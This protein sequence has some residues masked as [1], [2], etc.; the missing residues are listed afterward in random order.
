MDLSNLDIIAD[1]YRPHEIAIRKVFRDLCRQR[2]DVL[3][4]FIDP[5]DDSFLS[6]VEMRSVITDQIIR[7]DLYP[8][9]K[10][11]KL[12][13]SIFGIYYITESID[14]ANICRDFNLFINRADVNRQFWFYK[15]VEMELLDEGFVSYVGSTARST[16]PELDA[17]QFVDLLH[18][19]YF[20]PCYQEQHEFVRSRVPYQNFQDCGDLRKTMLQTKISVVIESYHERTD[21]I[22]FSEKIFRALQVPRPWLLSAATGSVDRLRN[23][24]FDLFDDYIDHSYDAYCTKFDTVQRDAAILDQ[25]VRMQSFRPTQSVLDDWKKRYRSNLEI[26][27]SWHQTWKQD[28]IEFITKHFALT[29]TTESLA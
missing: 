12:P 20:F 14:Q 21:A 4:S 26:L 17:Q 27:Q 10:I 19:Q 9:K 25:I 1:H 23:M 13:D 29:Y 8:N 6:S 22:A 2:P 24:G 5:V 15:I 7:P 28:L 16:N 11:L 18:Q 3:V